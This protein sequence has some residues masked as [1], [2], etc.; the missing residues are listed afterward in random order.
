[1]R[2]LHAPTN[3]AGQAGALVA[4]LRRLG[5]E[6]ELWEYGRHAF[7]YAA[8]RSV[9]ITGD[10]W[11]PWRTFAEAVERF[12]VV[13]LHFGRSLFPDWPGVPALWD[14]PLY[15]V[16][17]RRLFHTWHG[18]DCAIRRIHV[19]EN[20]WSYLRD[21]AMKADDDRTAKVIEIFR[22]YAE[23]TFV[24]APDY[25]RFVPDAELM[26]RVIDLHRWPDREPRQR[27]APIVLHVPSRRGK[28]GTDHVLAGMERLRSEGLAFDFR[29]LEG[30]SNEAVASAIAEADVVVD[31]VITGDYEVVSLEA[32][33]SG[34]VAVANLQ[35]ASLA[36]FPGAPVWNVDPPSFV[37]RMRLLI[38]DL[39]LR[40]ELA[41]RGRA[42]VG[43]HHDADLIATR[44]VAA[45]SRSPRPI[46][47]AALPD[48][49]SLAPARRIE[50]LEA[51][52]ASAAWREADYRR[53]LGLP[54]ERRVE[55]SWKDRLPMG[56]RLVLRRWRARLTQALRR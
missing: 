23:Q 18:A 45:Y 5:H 49:V 36:A 34:R 17:G 47:A 52:L 7:G 29:L 37:D 14:V 20:P 42:Y 22:T 11:L 44:L 56:L 30:V 54:V 51:R 48:W 33:A 15:R 43:G 24:V 46:E 35:A 3:P 16:L 41:A 4:A 8:D 2:I 21:P 13:H 28:K 25:L 55:R 1:M 31:N 19:A 50:L 26:P 6:A 9:D 53:R 32:M 39:D 10:P 27:T 12:D 38:T 40:R